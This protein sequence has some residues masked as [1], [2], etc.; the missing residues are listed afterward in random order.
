MRHLSLVFLLSLLVTADA[1]AQALGRPADGVELLEIRSG[2]Q[3]RVFSSK[4]SPSDAAQTFAVFPAS[5]VEELEAEGILPAAEARLEVHLDGIATFDVTCTS[6]ECQGES[7]F[8]DSFGVANPDYEFTLDAEARFWVRPAINMTI[9][10]DDIGLVSVGATGYLVP[11]LF[12]YAGNQCGDQDG[13]GLG[14]PL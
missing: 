14:D 10:D 8:A 13:N 5:A 9:H 3:W 11:H 4:A 6:S 1:T 2:A 7:N 12:G